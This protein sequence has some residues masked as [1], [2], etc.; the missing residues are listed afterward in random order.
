MK[1][2]SVLLYPTAYVIRFETMRRVLDGVITGIN[3]RLSGRVDM[4]NEPISIA[5]LHDLQ[6]VEKEAMDAIKDILVG[7]H[8]V[9]IGLFLSVLKRVYIFHCNF[10][11]VI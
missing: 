2:S 1:K 8:T 4:S 5:T 3:A 11:D 7:L 6:Y 9:D 10:T